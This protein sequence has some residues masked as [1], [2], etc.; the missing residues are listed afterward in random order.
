M[1]ES[2]NPR[3]DL[4]HIMES[5]VFMGMVS[6]H[7]MEKSYWYYAPMKILKELDKPVVTKAEKSDIIFIDM[8]NLAHTLKTTTDTY[9]TVTYEINE[10]GDRETN[11]IQVGL[12]YAMAGYVARINRIFSNP[13][14]FLVCDEGDKGRKLNEVREITKGDREYTP[15]PYNESLSMDRFINVCAGHLSSVNRT[16]HTYAPN[17]EADTVI[18]TMINTFTPNLHKGIR[19][20]Y[21]V[22]N[23]KD[24]YHTVGNPNVEYCSIQ[25]VFDIENHSVDRSI[26]DLDN[27]DWTIVSKY[28]V[29][30]A[31]L[32]FKKIL[33]GKENDGWEALV[34]EDYA[35]KLINSR[36]NWTTQSFYDE[37]VARFEKVNKR[38]LA[39]R[40][41]RLLINNKCMPIVRRL[42]HAKVTLGVLFTNN[43]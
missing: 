29:N 28:G 5:P 1:K 12:L 37:V 26:K 42:P 21:V 13:V 14:I 19:K 22:G 36:S 31:F 25:D 3:Y 4:K 8:T 9:K 2:D 43:D 6:S 23:D 15:V 24:T 7:F 39:D 34:P 18:N 32:P 38:T 33:C 11:D 10:E 30:P 35:I 16:Y 27:S 17:Q 41:Q 20:I 40:I